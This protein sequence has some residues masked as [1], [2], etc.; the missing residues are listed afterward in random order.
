MTGQSTYHSTYTDKVSLLC[1]SVHASCNLMTGQST[2][3]S[4]YTNNVSLLCV[5]LHAAYNSLDVQ[6]TFHNACTEV[7][8]PY[9]YVQ[10]PCKLIVG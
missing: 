3:H 5:K 2:Y 10:V 1:V 6:S 4:T 7:L 8:V 9:E